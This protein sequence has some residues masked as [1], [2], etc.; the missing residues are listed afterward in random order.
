MAAFSWTDRCGPAESG[1]FD[2]FGSSESSE[3]QVI[4]ASIQPQSSVAPGQAAV[5]YDGDV[6][7]GGGWI[8]AAIT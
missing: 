2:S 8:D 5:C 7:L 3:Y 4:A 6:V 1:S